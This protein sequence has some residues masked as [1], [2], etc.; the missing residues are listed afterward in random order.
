MGLNIEANNLRSIASL[1]GC[2]VGQR[3]FSYL[4]LSVGINHRQTASWIKLVDRIRRRLAKWN[5]KNMSLGGRVTLIQCEDSSKIL[6]V[7]WEDICK[8]KG[9]GG[10]GIRDLGRFNLALLSKWVWRFLNE[11]GRLWARIIKSRYGGLIYFKME[12]TAGGG[13]TQATEYFR[14]ASR[15][16]NWKSRWLELR[17]ERLITKL[18]RGCGA[19][20]HQK[21]NKQS[22]GRC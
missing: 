3:P 6:W 17:L 15:T 2:E 12:Q 7:S 5:D 11:P 20:I 13:F 10:L 21:D 14:R 9:K 22:C 8:D 18:S 16:K 1:L 4:G 19:V